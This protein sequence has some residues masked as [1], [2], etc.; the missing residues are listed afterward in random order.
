MRIFEHYNMSCILI[1]KY[2]LNLELSS[3]LLFQGHLQTTILRLQE[4]LKGI[5]LTSNAHLE[6]Q[7]TLYDSQ[8]LS[9]GETSLL[10]SVYDSENQ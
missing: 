6:Y 3:H 5:R 8:L 4:C 1:M 10:F 9:L 7:A 2:V